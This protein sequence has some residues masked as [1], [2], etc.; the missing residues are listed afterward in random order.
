[1]VSCAECVLQWQM[2]SDHK[3]PEA[4]GAV[5]DD[6]MS[7][8]THPVAGT[9]SHLRGKFYNIIRLIFLF[10]PPP[11]STLTGLTAVF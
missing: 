3:V 2:E 1:M 8:D 7:Q 9:R 4:V 6:V 11:N 10:C 5:Q